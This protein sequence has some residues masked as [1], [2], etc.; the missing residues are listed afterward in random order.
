MR[1]TVIRLP[2][3]V[4]RPSHRTA[5][6]VLTHGLRCRLLAAGCWLLAPSY[7][8]QHPFLGDPEINSG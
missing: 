6:K 8:V 5:S 1:E 2:F 4:Y 7:F 3:T